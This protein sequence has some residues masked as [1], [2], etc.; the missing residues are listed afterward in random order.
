MDDIDDDMPAGP[1]SLEGA[2]PRQ[3]MPGP[4]TGLERVAAPD[5]APPPSGQ[6]APEGSTS[7][8][9]SQIGAGS[10]LQA[11]GSTN[12]LAQSLSSVPLASLRGHD[13]D[14]LFDEERTTIADG[15]TTEFRD[16]P[17]TQAPPEEKAA[18]VRPYWETLSH[19]ERVDLLTLDVEIL[20]QRANEVIAKAQKTLAA[21]KAEAERTKADSKDSLDDLAVARGGEGQGPVPEPLMNTAEML[22]V[23]RLRDRST[24]KVWQW[25]VG[26]QVFFDAESFRQCVKKHLDEDLHGLLPKE[27]GRPVEKPAEAALRQRMR[28]LPKPQFPCRTGWCELLQKVHANTRQLQGDMIHPRRPAKVQRATFDQ[29]HAAVR[30]IKVE[31]II[32]MLEALEQEH[33][34]LMWLA[35]TSGSLR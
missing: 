29:M 15:L 25:P 4:A 9:T 3:A 8:E 26:G 31:R 11:P 33:E 2:P 28:D 35:L 13:H 6:A 23:R 12:S 18:L 22:D 24:W 30:E 16:I 34:Y 17:A 19:K 7:H 32:T 10:G 14:E 1:D 21:R 27:E 5:E 20:R